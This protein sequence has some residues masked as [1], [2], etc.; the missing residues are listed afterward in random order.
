MRNDRFECL[1]YLFVVLDGTFDSIDESGN[2]ILQRRFLLF[3][4]VPPLLLVVFVVF[5][6]GILIIFYDL[7]IGDTRGNGSYTIITDE[8][9]CLFRNTT[10][11]SW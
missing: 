11:R 8:G 4:L 3:L 1:A 9:S 2:I 7:D 6:T 5:V 10:L